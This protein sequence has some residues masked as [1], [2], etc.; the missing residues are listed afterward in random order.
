MGPKTAERMGGLG[1][2]VGADLCDRDMNFMIEHF[3]KSAEYLYQA[4]HGVDKRQ[5]RPDRMPSH[6]DA[7]PVDLRSLQSARL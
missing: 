4:A 5:V 7:A 3:G 1:I 2:T 6:I